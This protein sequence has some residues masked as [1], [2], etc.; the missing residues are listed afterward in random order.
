MTGKVGKSESRGKPDGGRAAK[1][2]R[3][4]DRL[5]RQI[6]TTAAVSAT[7]PPPGRLANKNQTAHLPVGGRTG[8]DSRA[9]E[10]LTR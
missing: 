7:P 2:H 8:R 9:V 5:P 6:P 1:K 4:G 3:H 10:K